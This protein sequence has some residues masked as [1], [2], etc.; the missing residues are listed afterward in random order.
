LPRFDRAANAAEL[1]RSEAHGT[2][3]L[4]EHLRGENC[5][6]RAGISQK[7]AFDPSPVG[8]LERPIT[9]GCGSRSSDSNQ[10]PLMRMNLRSPQW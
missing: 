6:V 7:R 3:E 9:T 4:A 1:L 10:P 2:A 8:G 5:R